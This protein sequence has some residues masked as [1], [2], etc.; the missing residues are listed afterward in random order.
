MLCGSLDNWMRQY[1]TKLNTNRVAT[2]S[3][4]NGDLQ[5]NSMYNGMYIQT[6]CIENIY[7]VNRTDGQLIS[8]HP[9]TKRSYV[10]FT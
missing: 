2:S 8:L 4:S 1:C 7:A 6:I 3:A 10:P 9:H 5:T